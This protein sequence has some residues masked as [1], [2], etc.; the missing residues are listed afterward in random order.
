MFPLPPV[1]PYNL[2]CVSPLVSLAHRSSKRPSVHARPSIDHGYLD[3]KT[4][5][6]ELIQRFAVG[7]VCSSFSSLLPLMLTLRARARRQPV[8]SSTLMAMSSRI[9]AGPSVR[10]VLT[11]LMTP[12]PAPPPPLP[13]AP[14]HSSMDLQIPYHLEDRVHDLAKVPN[15]VRTLHLRPPE[16]LLAPPSCL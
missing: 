15:I 9:F 3:L 2:A 5:E 12:P 16:L 4:V 11:F 10:L 1:A 8:S 7:R 13:P 14:S 6:F